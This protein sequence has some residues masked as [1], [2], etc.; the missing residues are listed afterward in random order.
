MEAPPMTE[1]M[2]EIGP[3]T[4]GFSVAPM[5]ADL[6]PSVVSLEESCGLN[7]R[8]LE[9]YGRMLS[10]P[11]A[12]LLVA[13]AGA[14]PVSPVS[15]ISRVI[16]VFSGDVVVDEL[17]ID[18]L[19]VSERWRRKGI[20]RTL[21]KRALMVAAGLG[22]RAATLEVRSANSSARAFYEEERFMPVGLRKRYYADPPDDALLLS[23]EI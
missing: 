22:A 21:L 10:D 17:Q 13:L 5:T 9:G 6:L 15:H 1:P 3:S 19:A 20:A 7:S 12:V 11:N 18:N 16:G 23:R 2:T 4:G 8:G 14:N